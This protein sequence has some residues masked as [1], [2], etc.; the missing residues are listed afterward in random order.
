MMCMKSLLSNDAHEITNPTGGVA[1]G[2]PKSQNG[3]EFETCFCT[4]AYVCMYVLI[5]DACTGTNEAMP[6]F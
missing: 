6:E 5:S 1:D 4:S 3:S 2:L